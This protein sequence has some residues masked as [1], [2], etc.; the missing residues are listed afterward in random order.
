VRGSPE[1]VAELLSADFIEVGASGRIYDRALAISMLTGGASAQRR[2]EGFTARA[3]SRSVVLV[4]YSAVRL[5]EDGAPASRSR[6]SSLWRREKGEWRMV[7]HQG[8]PQALG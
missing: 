7:F 1:R 8:T 6:R 2:I 3:V 5:G 4:T